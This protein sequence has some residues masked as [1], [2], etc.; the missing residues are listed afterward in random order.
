[1][2]RG[3]EVMCQFLAL[4]CGIIVCILATKP[5]INDLND[6]KTSWG[7]LIV[8]TFVFILGFLLA[9]KE[10]FTDKVSQWFSFLHDWAGLGLYILFLGGMCVSFYAVGRDVWFYLSVGIVGVGV[11]CILAKFVLDGS[12]KSDPLLG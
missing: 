3:T 9:I 11:L 12:P 5:F 4:A 6:I 10:L 1:M 8:D 2:T 7:H